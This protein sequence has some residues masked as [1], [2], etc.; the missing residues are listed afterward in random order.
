MIE[1]A[2]ADDIRFEVS[3][4]E[5]K[6][7]GV[8]YTIDTV[9]ELKAINKTARYFF[10]IGEDTLEELHKWKDISTLLELCEFI[11]FAR[12]GYQSSSSRPPS[13]LEALQKL[14]DSVKHGRLIEVSSSEV[15]YR[16]AEGMSIRYLVPRLVEMYIYEHNLYRPRNH[17]K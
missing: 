3:D 9:K 5:I 12:P 14:Y 11:V 6:R 15:R 10:I 16:I 2:I 7:G 8:S 17:K 13:R 1:S 4:I